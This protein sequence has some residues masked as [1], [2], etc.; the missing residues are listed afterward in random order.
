LDWDTATEG[1]S[2]SGVLATDHADVALASDGTCAGHASWDRGSEGKILHLSVPVTAT[3]VALEVLGDSDWLPVGSCT[4]G[5]DHALVWAS[6]VGVDLVNS[7]HDLESV[8]HDSVDWR[9]MSYLTT[10]SDLR[11]CAAVHCHDLC[12]ASIDGIVA[13]TKGLTASSCGVATEASRVLLEGVAA[14]AVT[15]SGGV[16]TDGRTLTTGIS[17]SANDGTVAS[18]ER[19]G[20]HKAESNNGGSR[21]VHIY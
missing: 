14:S 8:S 2:T 7:H 6:T 15:R 12:G 3:G 18:H 21:E 5:V 9:M 17:C 10:S 13:S 1:T 4:C 19:R 16:N 11:K 20:S